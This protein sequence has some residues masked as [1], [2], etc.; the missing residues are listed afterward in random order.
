M[1]KGLRT[2]ILLICDPDWIAFG[3][4]YSCKGLTQG[5]SSRL[6]R[7]WVLHFI[8]LVE[9][10]RHA[11]EMQNPRYRGGLVTRIGFEKF[12]QINDFQMNVRLWRIE[13]LPLPS[14]FGTGIFDRNGK[15]L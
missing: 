9:Q 10:A 11:P 4:P 14:P 3:D 13:P 1:K 8:R 2:V 5:S 7:Y 15:E 12:A 6:R